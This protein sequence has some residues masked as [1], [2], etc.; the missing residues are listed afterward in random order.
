MKVEDLMT[1]DVRTV[2]TEVSLKDVAAMLAEHRIGG[3]PVVDR[4]RMPLGVITKAD[5][6]MKELAEPPTKRGL[7]G[8]R[9]R[10]LRHEG[11]CTDGG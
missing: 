10:W 11:R 5:I 4:A 3:M 1:R 6:V 9:R 2:L 7:F 8:R